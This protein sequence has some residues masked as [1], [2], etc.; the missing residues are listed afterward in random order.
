MVVSS[1]L[2]PQA[3]LIVTG[4]IFEKQV[5]P[6]VFDGCS[7]QQKAAGAESIRVVCVA[8]TRLICGSAAEAW[9][10][11]LLVLDGAIEGYWGWQ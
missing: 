10:H 11:Y 6:E 8:L 4:L 7:E 2:D 5:G 1:S 9:T 3:Q